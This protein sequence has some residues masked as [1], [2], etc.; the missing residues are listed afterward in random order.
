MTSFPLAEFDALDLSKSV[1]NVLRSS[2]K[3]Y[4]RLSQDFHQYRWMTSF[5]A[6]L[7]HLVCLNVVIYEYIQSFVLMSSS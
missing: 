4:N 7:S 5:N 6:G 3:K 1:A 2:N